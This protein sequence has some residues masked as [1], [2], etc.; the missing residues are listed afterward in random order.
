MITPT[1]WQEVLALPTSGPVGAT[2]I[3]RAAF[4]VRPQLLNIRHDLA[5]ELGDRLNGL[6][7]DPLLLKLE[8]WMSLTDSDLAMRAWFAQVHD[9]DVFRSTSAHQEL[10]TWYNYHFDDQLRKTSDTHVTATQ[11]RPHESTP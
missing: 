9:L 10:M 1:S 4:T 7:S 8:V 6:Q 3:H 5:R 11:S 2:Y